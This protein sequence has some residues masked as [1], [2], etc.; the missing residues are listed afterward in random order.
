[1]GRRTFSGLLL[2]F[3]E[4]TTT[5]T[6]AIT[7]AL[8]DFLKRDTEQMYPEYGNLQETIATYANV[9]PD[10]ILITNGS[11]QGIDLIF[12][13]FTGERD[14]VIIP[15]PSFA[16]FFQAAQSV[17]NTIVSP[18][19]RNKTLAFPLSEVI[20]MIDDA[21][22]LI[23]VCNPNNPTGTLVPI[24]DIEKIARVGK[25]AIVLVDEAYVEFSQTSAISLIRRYPNIIITR[26]LSKAFGLASQN[27][28]SCRKEYINELNKI[29]GPFDVNMLAQV[30]A[31]AALQ[32]VDDMKQYAREIMTRAK[33]MVEKFFKTNGILFYPSSANFILFQPDNAKRVASI[34]RAN[35]VLVRP[36]NK[37]GVQNTLR[38]TIGRVD[39]VK[40]F[41][42][43]YT[44]CILKKRYAF[45]DRDGTL[46]FEP[47]Y[48]SDKFC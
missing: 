16:M 17:G 32:N 41:M 40:K 14:T 30:A 8:I 37:P 21:V 5:P 11:D 19:Y 23:I 27:W 15:S 7:S 44:R 33:P 1:M 2:D 42:S 3:N 46:I 38:V 6:T 39:R 20:Q 28:L 10:Q 43:I 29:R 24:A 36:Q 35:G 13:T 45:I 34:L 12:R 18:E 48:V 9:N 31:V 26:T 47:Q 4:R 22:K 25:N